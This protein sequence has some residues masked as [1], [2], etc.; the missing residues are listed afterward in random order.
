ML[1]F[2][3]WIPLV[4][5]SDIVIP[6]RYDFRT[7]TRFPVQFRLRHFD[8]QYMDGF[9]SL[10][11]RSDMSPFTTEDDQND[12]D[13]PFVSIDAVVFGNIST[14]NYHLVDHFAM[15]PSS[16]NHPSLPTVHLSADL[17]STLLASIGDYLLTPVSGTEGLVVLNPSNPPM[18]AY[19]S[20]IFYTPL[21]RLDSLE[22]AASIQVGSFDTLFG[23]ECVANT[24]SHEVDEYYRIPEPAYWE[25]SRQL[26]ERGIAGPYVPINQI[27]NLP[28]IKFF[29]QL[30]DGSRACVQSVRPDEY[31]RPRENDPDML[32]IF[33]RSS[34]SNIFCDFGKILLRKIVLHV[35]GTNRRIGFGEPINEV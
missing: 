32:E 7:M 17:E 24:G 20:Q 1:S 30:H 22:F 9:A 33:V 27:E 29:I 35:D 16:F 6:T 3:P 15:L 26:E 10:D 4:V 5:S 28:E 13:I 31:L 25:F 18:Y 8:N 14:E 21:I 34:Q 12:L 23:S 19:Q 11:L 2:L